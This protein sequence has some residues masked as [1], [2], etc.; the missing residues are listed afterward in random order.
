LIFGLRLFLWHVDINTFCREHQTADD[1]RLEKEVQ[2]V[3]VGKYKLYNDD[4]LDLLN[5]SSPSKWD[6]RGLFGARKTPVRS[7]ET[8]MVVYQDKH[9]PICP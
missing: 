8:H 7:R 5:P 9:A 1:T 4:M 6:V 3:V 2:D